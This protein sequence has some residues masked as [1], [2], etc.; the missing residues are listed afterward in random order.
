[1][2][3]IA[4]TLLIT[5]VVGGGALAG[6]K[7]INANEQPSIQKE[8]EQSLNK[9][10]ATVSNSKISSSNKTGY[11]PVNSLI[12]FKDENFIVNRAVRCCPCE[13]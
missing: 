13:P 2:K 12:I 7:V 9:V 11:S 4:A 8:L 1:M 6:I 3:K 10:E 5:T